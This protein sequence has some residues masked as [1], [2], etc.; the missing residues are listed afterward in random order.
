MAHFAKLNTSNIVT[1]IQ[2]VNN[3]VITENGIE[4][5]E[6][7]INFLKNLYNEPDA[8]WKQTSFNTAFNTHVKGGT[9]FRGNY[10]GVNFTWDETNQIFW[11]IQNYPSWTKNV[12]TASWDPPIPRPTIVDDGQDPPVWI[13][14]YGWDEDLHQSDNTKGWV[15][16]KYNEDNSD[17]SDTNTYDWN[18]SSW[19]VRSQN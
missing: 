18:G 14:S 7:G 12:T 17:H 3:E 6:L 13:W 19:V 16:V 8:I 10:A 15:G 5:E 9:P 11:S 4:K 1:E 2:V